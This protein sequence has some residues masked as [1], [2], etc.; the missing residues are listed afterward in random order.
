MKAVLLAGGKGSRLKPYTISIPKPLVPVGDEPI[1]EI[2]VKQLVKE[3]IEDITMAVGH[4]AEQIISYFGDGSRYGTKISYSKEERALGTVGPLRLIRDGLDDTFLMMNGDILTDLRYGELIG[5]HKEK[6]AEATIA[7]VK[8]NVDIDYGV[9]KINED[10]IVGWEEKPTIHYHVSTGIY[11]LEPSALDLIPPEGKFDLPD[12]IKALISHGREVA[13]YPFEGY[14]LDIGRP[15]DY[16]KACENV[17]K[18]RK[19]K[20]V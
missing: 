14:W 2:V 11:V 1:M 10:A 6:G 19:G 9:V 15:E 12:L 4:M 5:Y 16:E 20:D 8:R 18:V 7:T 13:S 3:G 17:T